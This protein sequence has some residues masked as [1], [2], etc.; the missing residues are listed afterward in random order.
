MEI[1]IHLKADQSLHR[2]HFALLLNSLDTTALF[3]HRVDSG[4]TG[5]EKRVFLQSR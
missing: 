3:L 2:R 4:E 5:S 1:E